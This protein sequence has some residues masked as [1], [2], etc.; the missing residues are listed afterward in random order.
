MS[1]FGNAKPVK[2][3]GIEVTIVSACADETTLIVNG[4]AYGKIGRGKAR[5][6]DTILVNSVLPV[7]RQAEALVGLTAMLSGNSPEQICKLIA[8]FRKWGQK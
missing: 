1:L 2:A 8:D 6:E 5:D 4:I 3:Y 7:Y